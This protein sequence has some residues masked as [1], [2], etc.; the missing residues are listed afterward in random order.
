LLLFFHLP[1]LTTSIHFNSLQSNSTHFN[2]KI[3]TSTHFNQLQPTSTHHLENFI[4]IILINF[5]L[6]Y[7]NIPTSTHFNKKKI[8]FNSLQSTSTYLNQL[9]HFINPNL[10]TK[11]TDPQSSKKDEILKMILTSE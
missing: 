11:R 10:P 6:S 7:K 9:H 2:K 4:F 1:T 8:N 3:L 5:N